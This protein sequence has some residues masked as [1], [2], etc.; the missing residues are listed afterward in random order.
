MSRKIDVQEANKWDEDELEANVA[1]LRTRGMEREADEALKI[2]GA[3]AG[4][5]DKGDGLEDMTVEEL[6]DMAADLDI[7][8]RSGMKKAQLVDA[9]RAAQ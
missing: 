3:E 4:E 9:I 2:A 7:D 6:Q 8:G 1:Y 5:G